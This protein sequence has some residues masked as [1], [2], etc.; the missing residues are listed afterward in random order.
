MKTQYN[1]WQ[2]RKQEGVTEQLKAQ[3]QMLWV[4]KIQKFRF[5]WYV[6]FSFAFCT[7]IASYSACIFSTSSEAVFIPY[8]FN[9]FSDIQNLKIAAASY[10]EGGSV[11]ELKQKISERNATAKDTEILFTD[12]CKTCLPWSRKW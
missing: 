10:A 11:E 4:G 6:F 7:V 1:S 3:D 8:R 9:I 5:V 12:T 2:Y